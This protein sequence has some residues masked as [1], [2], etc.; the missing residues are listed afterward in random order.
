M[1]RWSIVL[2]G[3][4][5][6]VLAIGVI[7]ELLPDGL[8]VNWCPDWI[9]PNCVPPPSD[10]ISGTLLG[11]LAYCFLIL[12]GIFVFLTGVKTRSWE[13]NQTQAKRALRMFGLFLLIGGVAE[14]AWASNLTNSLIQSF[15]GYG[16]G[17]SV[18]AHAAADPLGYSG[19]LLI[20]SSVVLQIAV[21]SHFK[22]SGSKRVSGV[23]VGLVAVAFMIAAQRETAL[24]FANLTV[25]GPPIFV[26]NAIENF[27]YVIA[28]FVPL[29][30]VVG[31]AGLVLALIAAILYIGMK[32]SKYATYIVVVA[33]VGFAL[34]GAD[35]LYQV[36]Y[37]FTGQYGFLDGV[38]TSY[39]PYVLGGVLLAVSAGLMLAASGLELNYLARSI[40]GASSAST[41]GLVTATPEGQPAQHQTN[42]PPTPRSNTR[43]KVIALLFVVVFL[44]VFFL[45]PFVP[46]DM[47]AYSGYQ[48]YGSLSVTINVSP[49]YALFKCGMVGGGQGTISIGGYQQSYQVPAEFSCG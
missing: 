15:G 31:D 41:S 46:Y 25:T 23:V 47:A 10:A 49:S 28:T 34:F 5:L 11:M 19:I 17:G 18:L 43:R 26:T 22:P 16:F 9:G 13:F 36:A 21:W 1:G 8:L 24:N 3:V 12:S 35:L 4:G 37:D 33:T 40:G 27:P 48:G 7:V 39:I 32:S 6:V 14:F 20:V 42:G 44:V 30:G 2:Y 38:S 45:V 29:P